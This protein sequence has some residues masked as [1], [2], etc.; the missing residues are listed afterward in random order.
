M[1]QAMLDLLSEQ[2]FDD[3]QIT[4]LTARAGVGYATFFRHYASTRDVLNE[5]ASDEIAELLSMSIPVL[6]QEDSAASM[7]AL[8]RFIQQRKRLWQTLLT[9][10]AADTV[11]AEFVRQARQW[12]ARHDGS[13]SAVPIDLGT[14]CA[15]TSTIAALAWWLESGEDIGADAFADHIDRLIISPFLS[16]R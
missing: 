7:R 2:R 3:I 5:I 13:P 10:G 9:G 14:V 6:A 4:Q 11:R 8:C 15:A 16:A 1:R 12:S